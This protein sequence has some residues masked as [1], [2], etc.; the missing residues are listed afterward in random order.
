V[1]NY[2]EHL[3]NIDPTAAGFGI[4]ARD[5]VYDF[6]SFNW[7]SA[8]LLGAL[9]P[10]NRGATLVMAEKFSA[11]RF[12][13]HLRDH[14]V[15]IAAGN[16]TT[17]NMLLNSE[18]TAHRNNLPA[19]RFLT[20][21]SAPLTVEEWQRFEQRFGIPIAQGYG[22]SETGWIAAISGE[23]RR[24]GTVGRPLAYHDLDIVDR[25][26]RAPAGRHGRPRRDRRLAFAQLPLSRRGRQ[27]DG[28]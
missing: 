21:S 24:L 11:S 28:R 26:R 7:A 13:Q 10:V 1:L 22:S 8:Q 15:T 3:S 25:R 20:S 14:R 5:R 19:L 23:Q 12:F 18:S 4:S 27:R 17:I 16:P 6:R 2:R 9:V